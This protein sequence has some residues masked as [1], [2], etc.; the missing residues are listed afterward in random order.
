M[1]VEDGT[2]TNNKQKVDS[3]NQAHTRAF[4]SDQMARAALDGNAFTWSP[5]TYNYTG[6]DTIL[7][8]Q[9]DSDLLNLVITDIWMRGDTETDATVHFTDG[10]VFAHSGTNVV[11]VNTNRASGKSADATCTGDEVSNTQGNVYWEGRLSADTELHI[12]TRGAVI[13]GLDDCIAVD[14]VTTGAE[15]YVTIAGYFT[16]K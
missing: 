5:G 14:F 16:P 4:T 7:L 3:L 12:D 6:V 10:A 1:L 15:A 2:G 13:L 8:V 9:N 11:G